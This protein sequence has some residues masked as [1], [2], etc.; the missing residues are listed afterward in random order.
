MK[1]SSYVHFYRSAEDTFDRPKLEDLLKRRF[2]YHQ[3]FSIHGGVSGLY[4]FGPIGAG[5]KRNLLSLWESFFVHE[6]NMLEVDTVEMTPEPVLKA[7]GH[8]DKFADLMVKDVKNGE[9]FRLDHLIKAQLQK[10]VF[11]LPLSIGRC[12][13]ILLLLKRSWPTRRPA[14]R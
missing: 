13:I 11:Y 10:V 2:Y 9:C 7:S 5:V 4:D 8:V 3:S 6:E 12:V 14:P 1:L